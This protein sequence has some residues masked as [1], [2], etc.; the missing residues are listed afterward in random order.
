M[1]DSVFDEGASSDFAPPAKPAKAVKAVKAKAAPK[2]A[3]GPAKARGRPPK[4][5]SAPAKTKAKAAP[6]KKAKDFSDDENSDI[7]MDEAALDDDESLL[8]DTPPKQ[9]K[10]P[11]VKKSSGQPLADI[12]NESFGLDS[13]AAAKP[14]KGG[15]SDKYQMVSIGERSELRSLTYT[16]YAFGTHHGAP[17]HIHW[18]RRA[19]GKQNVGLQRRSRVYGIS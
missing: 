5:P 1:D 12:A 14:K 13:P 2:K 8:A 4:D 10:A 3:A 7:N 18:L 9:K 11:A 19:A 17:R 16:A 6:K 15:A